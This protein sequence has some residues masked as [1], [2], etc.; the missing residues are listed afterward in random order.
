[1]SESVEG[2]LRCLGKGFDVACD[3]R[4]KY[5]KGKE[6]VVVINEEERRELAVPGFGSVSDVSVDIKCDKGDRMRYQ[7]DVLEFNRVLCPSSSSSPP[8]MCFF[9]CHCNSFG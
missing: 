6:R 5:C 9:L 1:M 3:F 2:A 7:S 8:S 4:A